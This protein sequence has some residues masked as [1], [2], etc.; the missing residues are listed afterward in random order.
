[1]PEL[2]TILRERLRA[3]E[4]PTVPHP[5][6]D[7][8]T[9]F[10]EELLPPGER[11]Q[12]LRHLSA[13]VECRDVVALTMPD[14]L[15]PAEQEQ[16]VLVPAPVR[17]RRW[18]FTPAFGM[19]GSIAVMIL[20]LALILQ[21]PQK[22][23][24][25]AASSAPAQPAAN[26]APPTMPAGTAAGQPM[27]GVSIT[28]EAAPAPPAPALAASR[29]RQ[30]NAAISSPAKRVASNFERATA[31]A[32]VSTPAAGS[33]PEVSADLR[34]QDYVNKTFLANAFDPRVAPPLYRDL[35]LP[36]A[37]IPQSQPAF[38]P[39]NAVANSTL[40]SAPF[41]IPNA[42]QAS[43]STL[44]LYPNSEQKNQR[45]LTR[46]L[47]LSRRQLAKRAP[48]D[49]SNL[50]ASAMFKPGT[51]SVQTGGDAI[52]AKSEAPTTN[53]GNGTLAQSP[54]FNNGALSFSRRSLLGASAYQWKVVEG[55]LLRSSDLRNW[56][57][58][59]PADENV[60]FKVVSA[61]GPEIWAGG[62]DAALMHS[63]DGGTTWQRVTL[64]ASATGTINSI[65]AAGLNLHV[66]SS[67]G[68]SWAS[69]DGGKSWSL[70]D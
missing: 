27:A 61:N 17:R 41:A 16:E 44:T 65:E 48:I 37:P 14:A 20:G 68:Q 45:I 62:E 22:R 13:C 15:A 47:D 52:A 60:H 7:V 50:G 56:S 64:G 40:S 30:D 31:S 12:V 55:K 23:E 2:S 34:S 28:T 18:F 43:S 9:A 8:L 4:K 25:K 29:T 32:E 11:E 63:H 24:Q 49:A 10:A 53:N 33:S 1:M 5:D 42:G 57:E 46:V 21:L 70:Q 59:N 54:A 67:S 26:Q 69:Q 51:T 58:E 6:A 19:A 35:D 38:A 66:R 36:Q 3:A 39:P